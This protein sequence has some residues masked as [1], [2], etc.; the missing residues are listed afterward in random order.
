E[1]EP[2]AGAESL[3][4]RREHEVGTAAVVERVVEQSRVE[5]AAEVEALYVG[6]IE[7][8]GD[9]VGGRELAR[10]LDHLRRDVVAVGV[11]AVARCEA[12]HPAGAA[13]ELDQA[14]ACVKVQDLED[15]A[16]VDQQPG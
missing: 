11:E 14:H 3:S 12:G 16:E 1:E 10:D 2:A 6:D 13:A 4:G 9:G 7:G 5:A 15:V 8:C